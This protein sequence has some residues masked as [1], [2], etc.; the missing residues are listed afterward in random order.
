MTAAAAVSTTCVLPPFL[1]GA[2]S[3]QLRDDLGFG[4]TS[5]GI[6]V[7]VSFTVA[8]VTSAVA[9]RL[10][11]RIGPATGMRIAAGIAAVALLG[12]AASSSVEVLTA[13]LALAGFANTGAQTGSN[14]L[15]AR[16][17]PRARQA[18]AFG[19]KQ[20]AIPAAMLLGGIAVPSIGLT[21]GWQWAFVGGAALALGSAFVVPR[22]PRPRKQARR[23][24][25]VLRVTPTL[26]VL[27]LAG[28]LGATAANT[29]G[30][31]LVASTVRIGVSE[32]AAGLLY[33]GGSAV[34]LVTRVGVGVFADRSR[35]SD[36][37]PMVGLM[38][39][40]GAVGFGLLA[41][42]TRGALVPGVVLAYALGWGW[43]GL[44]N[45]AVVARHPEAP[46]AATGITQTGVYFGAVT[47]PIAFGLLAERVSY[48]AAWSV[49]LACS[50]AAALA[51]LAAGRVS[52]RAGR[53]V[54]PPPEAGTLTG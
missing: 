45:W 9:G 7:A 18:T 12:M 25:G 16:G 29:L 14:L 20:S 1:V 44:F 49:A 35:R 52:D 43:P 38:L 31:F 15:I 6:A 11:E 47:G 13:F 30:A 54:P 4:E 26:V 51:V 39:I 28:G 34:G 22:S 5:L 41:T 8:G 32:G 46:A 40:G 2:L 27:G 48:G 23:D 19:V 50:L 33:A 21:V 10:M 17:V 36:T 53:V 24:A 42:G 3:V 37:L